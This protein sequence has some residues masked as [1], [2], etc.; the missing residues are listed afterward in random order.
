MTLLMLDLYV[1]LST[2]V[3]IPPC[4]GGDAIV[5]CGPLSYGSL[6]SW[7]DAAFRVADDTIAKTRTLRARFASIKRFNDA[8]VVEPNAIDFAV[9][10]YLMMPSS[11]SGDGGCFSRER[12][13]VVE[14][15]ILQATGA[16]S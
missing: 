4:P 3:E 15:H 7:P 8:F 16:P 13:S 11:T 9:A 12:D 1:S 10:G 5:F 2:I 6:I 14:S